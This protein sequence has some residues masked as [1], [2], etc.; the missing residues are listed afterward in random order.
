MSLSPCLKKNSKAATISS[1][2]IITQ[3]LHPRIITFSKV[4]IQR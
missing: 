4:H 2:I 3:F 1:K